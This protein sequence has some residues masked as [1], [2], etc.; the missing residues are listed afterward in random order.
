MIAHLSAQLT[1]GGHIA[2]RRLHEAL[3]RNGMESRFYFGAGNTNDLSYKP[4]YQNQGFFWRNAAAI[5]TS[6]QNRRQ[7]PGG[8]LHSPGWIRKT[9]FADLGV[10][11]D[12]I[13]LHDVNRWLDQP[14]FF[15]SL[16]ASLPIVWSLHV[17]LPITGGCI[18]TGDCDGFTKE[19]GHCPQLQK[20]YAKDVSN[21][22][23]DFKRKWY[24]KLNL[25]LV[26][27]SQWTTDQINRSAL[28]RHAKSIRTIHY[29]INVDQFKPVNKQ[30]ARESLGL[31][32]NKFVIGFACS[33]FHE[34]RK[35]AHLLMEALK[36]LPA[37]EVTLVVFGGGLWPREAA[38]CETITLGSIGS[39][40]LQ[41][42]FYSAL[43]AFA[44]PTQVETFG[45]VAAEA[46]ACETPVV[47]YPGGG[48]ADVV[49]SGETG[50]VEPE[51]GNVSGL[52]RMLYWMWKHPLERKEMGAAGRK[53][54]IKNFSDLLMAD[55][56]KK[57]YQEIIEQQKIL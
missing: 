40:R 48:L 29:G 20:R 51:Y 26:G 21:R 6:W 17:L 10:I 24:D 11:P 43:D 16:P 55:K 35:G 1:G 39:P 2:A 15:N 57:L 37:K 34:R 22:F 18:Y 27:N 13:N 49:I 9:P 56:Y 44:M 28:A 23:F 30:V 52:T 19:C 31:D 12:I 3:C 53:R 45:L 46:M 25:H 14:S 7:A 36:G 32:Q 47:A 42:I 54:V 38:P 8:Y 4:V 5:L 41:S 33:D 50:L